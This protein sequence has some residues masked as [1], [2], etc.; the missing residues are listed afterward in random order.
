MI[1]ERVEQI[2]KRYATLANLA[3]PQTRGF[4]EWAWI[5]GGLTIGDALSALAIAR[6]SSLV[7]VCRDYLGAFGFE[8]LGDG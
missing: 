5:D 6:D 8:V 1:E 3:A 4:R 2:Q 7:G